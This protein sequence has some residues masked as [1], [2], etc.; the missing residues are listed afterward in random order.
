MRVI[1]STARRYEYTKRS[2]ALPGATGIL[3]WCLSAWI[4]GVICIG[5]AFF[6]CRELFVEQGL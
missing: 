5:G 6:L 1:V 3:N 2:I 4:A